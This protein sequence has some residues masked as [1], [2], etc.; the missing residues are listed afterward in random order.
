MEQVV[1]EAL[2]IYF[3]EHPQDAGKI[4]E[5]VILAAKARLAARAARDSVIR[6]G[7]LEGLALRVNW[8]IVAKATR[9]NANYILLRGTARA[10]APNKA[11]TDV[12]RP[13]CL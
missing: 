2:D 4:M 10:A 3:E 9:P 8:P 6:K 11:A 7:V 1:G 13:Y 12:F 5:K